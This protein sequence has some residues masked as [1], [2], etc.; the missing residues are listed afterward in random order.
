MEEGHAGTARSFISTRIAAN[1]ST[2]VAAYKNSNSHQDSRA[3]KIHRANH[4]IHFGQGL[5]APAARWPLCLS[6]LP[7]EALQVVGWQPWS[8][9][10]YLPSQVSI[11]KEDCH[12]SSFSLNAQQSDLKSKKVGA[13]YSKKERCL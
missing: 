9:G 1:I 12:F 2:Q 8:S 7:V 6:V 3:L 11:W 10:S 5:Q 4:T 13:L